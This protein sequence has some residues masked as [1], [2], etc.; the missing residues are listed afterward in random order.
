MSKDPLARYYQ[1]KQRKSQIWKKSRE[2]YQNLVETEKEETSKN[3]VV[4]NIKILQKTK[5]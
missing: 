3:M 1:K 5:N 2:R 4:N